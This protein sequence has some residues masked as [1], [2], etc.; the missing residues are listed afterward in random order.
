MVDE[1]QPQ[2][3]LFV[4]FFVVGRSGDGVQGL[5]CLQGKGLLVICDL[6]SREDLN[7]GGQNLLALVAIATA[8]LR[9][10]IHLKLSTTLFP[11][12]FSDTVI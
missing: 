5:S 6:S 9:V 4:R 2:L 3:L 7:D 10:N 1:L 12:L 11:S 8:A